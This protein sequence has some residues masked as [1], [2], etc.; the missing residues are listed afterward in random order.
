MGTVEEK[1]PLKIVKFQAEHIKRI[2]AIEIE[3]DPEDSVVVLTGKN[4]QGKTSI[5]DSIWCALGGKSSIPASPIAKGEESGSVILDLGE[6]TVSRSFTEGGNSYLSIKNKDGFKMT[7]PQTFLSSK[8]GDYA[9]DPLAFMR[10]RDDEQVKFLQGVVDIPFDSMKIKDVTGLV[11]GGPE[12]R[13]ICDREDAIALLDIAHKTVYERRTEINRDVSRLSGTVKTLAASILDGNEN[14]EPISA[15]TLIDARK[16]LEGQAED[17]RRVETQI[18]QGAAHVEQTLDRKANE[19]A[20]EISE[21]EKRLEAARAKLKSIAEERATTIKL[22]DGLKVKLEGMPIPDFTEIDARMATIDQHNRQAE[23]AARLRE[24]RKELSER[25][26][27]SSECSET[28]SRIKAYRGELVESAGLPVPGLGF[29][30]GIVT[31]NG[32]PLSQASGREQI[33]VSC[34]ICFAQNPSIGVMTVDVGWSELD[35]DGKNVLR[36]WAKKMGAQ[37]WVTKVAE[38]PEAEGFHIYDGEVVS[39]NGGAKEQK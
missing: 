28:L 26:Q 38:T 25:E 8:L 5:L 14:V 19:V 10:L 16:V 21:L 36:E 32:V 35:E 37:I 24:T 20:F 1:K 22:V 29:E 4:R 17:R 23:A 9:R 31:Y 12:F 15:K 30:S 34:A 2:K 3:P 18:K 6:F 7:S 39:V 13:A 11:F 27:A 33:E